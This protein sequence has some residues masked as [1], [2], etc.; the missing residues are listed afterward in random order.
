[1]MGFDAYYAF[2]R[3]TRFPTEM[4]DFYYI[5][6]GARLKAVAVDEGTTPISLGFDAFR[7]LG[8]QNFDFLFSNLIGLRE[9]MGVEEGRK[10]QVICRDITHKKLCDLRYR[11]VWS[12]QN[13]DLQIHVPE[14]GKFSYSVRQAFW[15]LMGFHEDGIEVLQ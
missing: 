14:E 15:F 2:V 12:G 5:K 9:V 10:D 3:T 13:I 4:M 7:P 1:M 11:D 6:E 8:E